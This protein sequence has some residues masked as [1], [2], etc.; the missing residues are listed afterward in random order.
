MNPGDVK[1]GALGDCWLLGAFSCLATNPQL[2]SNLIVYDGM[3]FGFCV[4]QFFKNGEWRRVFVDTFIPFNPSS[5]T[6]LY[7]HCQDPNEFWVPLLEKAYAKLH[8]SYQKLHGGAMNIG[9]V[10]L[11]G[12]IAEKFNFKDPATA[13]LIMTGQLWK[14]MKRFQASAFLMGCSNSQKDKDGI[15]EDGMGNQ[16]IL[17]NH[18]YSVIDVR[19]VDSLRLIRL[20]NPWGHGEWTGAFSDDDEEWDKHKG[21]KD[22]LSYSFSYDGNWWMTFQH[23]VENYNRLY[24]CRIFPESWQ[25]Y[26]IPGEWKGKTAGGPYP[27][28]IDRDEEAAI[29]AQN[30]P[31]AGMNNTLAQTAA[32]GLGNTALGGTAI[33]G[34]QMGNN[35]ATQLAG[36]VRLDSNDK[37]FNNPQYR[38]TITKPTRVFISLMQPDERISKKG[39]IPCNFLV[40]RSRVGYWIILVKKRPSLGGR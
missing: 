5:K 32:P 34:T 13:E 9:L 14:M 25:Q 21:L 40:V 27:V 1:Q 18:A 35:L 28:T 31:P 6:P 7:A 8:G 11:T 26:S 19:E 20:R 3:E 17:Y 30:N 16:G 23:F 24:L 29:M 37:W 12:G 36:G 39:Y 33:G 22:K 38:I 4:F 15:Q 10:D 2:L